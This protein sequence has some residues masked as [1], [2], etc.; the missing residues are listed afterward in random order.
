VVNEFHDIQPTEAQSIWVARHMK[1]T[2]EHDDI[3]SFPFLK[4]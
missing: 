3:T 4:R 1:T 2:R